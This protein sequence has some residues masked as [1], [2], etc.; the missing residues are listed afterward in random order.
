MGVASVSHR[1]RATATGS[2]SAGC[3]VGSEAGVPG[4]A[5]QACRVYSDPQGYR[6]EAIS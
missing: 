6:R 1:R 4:P 5:M 2:A 3:V